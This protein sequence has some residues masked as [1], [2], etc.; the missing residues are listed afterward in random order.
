MIKADN[1]A[2][3]FVMR[4]VNDVLEA[5][6]TKDIKGRGGFLIP[7]NALTNMRLELWYCFMEQYQVKRTPKSGLLVLEII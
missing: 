1:E 3:D 7:D 2:I 4:I 6:L 5:E